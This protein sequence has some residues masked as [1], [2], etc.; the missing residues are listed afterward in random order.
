MTL[1]GTTSAS[2]APAPLFAAEDRGPQL[3]DAPI[4]L[5]VSLA[6][7][8]LAA[9]PESH[10]AAGSATGAS[11]YETGQI[12]SVYGFPGIC[13]MGELGC[14]QAPEGAVARARELAAAHDAVNGDRGVRPALHLIVAVA[15]PYPGP[16]GTYLQWMPESTI[17]EWVEVA[18]RERVLLFLDVQIGWSDPLLEVRRLDAML[19]EPFVQLALDP[20]FATR[21]KGLPPG[22]AIGSVSAIQVNQVQAYL[23][24]LVAEH[25]LP[26]KV[27]VLHQFLP[28]MLPDKALYAGYPEVEVTV[29]MDGFGGQE[30]KISGYEAYALVG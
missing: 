6:V 12:V 9:V 4:L 7:L 20:E 29:D 24:A 14:H 17:R 5:E 16:D 30:A 3:G 2:S 13:F 10:A 23:A 15:Q 19:R 1:P 26:A 8:L 11:P 22:D 28:G 25:A 27:L 21:E 18:R